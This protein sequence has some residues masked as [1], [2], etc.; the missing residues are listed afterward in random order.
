MKKTNLKILISSIVIISIVCSFTLLSLSAYA[1]A[2][3]APGVPFLPDLSSIVES[4]VSTTEEETPSKKPSSA[5]S[6][7]LSD[8]GKFLD[9]LNIKENV[10]LAVELIDYLNNG[11]SFEAWVYENFGS[12]IEIPDSIKEASTY[13]LV[14]YILSN[15]LN[16]GEED[17]AVPTA[18]TKYAFTPSEPGSETKE[19]VT[20]AEHVTRDF[21]TKDT[22]APSTDAPPYVLGDVNFDESVTASDARIVLKASSKL[23]ELNSIEFNAADVNGDKRIT[24]KDARSILR[25]S[26]RLADSF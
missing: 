15:I 17:S 18:T 10:L 11:G 13:D 26:A 25:Y 6:N 12:D 8:F 21:P 1:D 22:T 7:A 24:A 20:T 4:Y 2:A 9:D 16:G 3:D 14:L 19:T 5:D 23:Y